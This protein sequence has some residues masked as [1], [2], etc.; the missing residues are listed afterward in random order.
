[1]ILGKLKGRMLAVG[2]KPVTAIRKALLPWSFGGVRW[3]GRRQLN[4][5]CSW[6]AAWQ[7]PA[8]SHPVYK[9][10][11]SLL[12]CLSG[13]FPSSGPPAFCTYFEIL[14]SLIIGS[15]PSLQ[16]LSLIHIQ[17]PRFFPMTRE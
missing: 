2:R 5:G 14:L 17:Q 1:M 8:P 15:F 4:L 13:A 7:L 12:R 10:S 6:Q 3:R 9:G 11:S 16:R